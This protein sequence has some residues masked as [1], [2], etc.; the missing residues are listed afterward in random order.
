ML[1]RLSAIALTTALS[2]ALALGPAAAQVP[3]AAP[4]DARPS[5][6]RPAIERP[7]IDCTR[8]KEPMEV[9][10]CGDRAL[11]A[12]DREVARLYGLAR[13]S[14]AG[15]RLEHL[16]ETQHGWALRRND[17]RNAVEQRACVQAAYLERIATLRLHYRAA[18]AEP[19]PSRGPVAFDCAGTGMTA[20]FVDGDPAL[21]YLRYR[22]AGHALAQVESASGARYAGAG[23]AEMW[24]KGAEATVTLPDRSPM[25]CRER[26]R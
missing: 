5:N 12:L 14:L 22:G 13:P 2:M 23:R 15:R 26:P 19:G 17:C 24:N 16:A 1:Q 3:T 4:R 7:S 18:R 20:T 6:D 9:L 10:V 8:A 21:A 11:F 25:T